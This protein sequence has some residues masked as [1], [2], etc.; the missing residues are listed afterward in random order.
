MGYKIYLANY[1]QMVSFIDYAT[2]MHSWATRKF[3]LSTTLG[4]SMDIDT[5]VLQGGVN[6][7]I[8]FAALR[9]YINQYFVNN[10][11]QPIIV[12]IKLVCPDGYRQSVDPNGYYAN[13]FINFY[14]S[15][16]NTYINLGYEERGQELVE[17][18]FIAWCAY[19]KQIH[20]KWMLYNAE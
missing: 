7:Y 1:E 13:F 11:E 18:P 6:G 10:G 19:V 17:E 4:V 16:E 5:R 14:S 20:K 9:G 2:D 3:T 15:G 8:A 12:D